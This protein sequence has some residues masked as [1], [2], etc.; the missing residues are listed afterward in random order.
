M[1][2]ATWRL[3]A[4]TQSAGLAGTVRDASGAAVPQAR[5][6]IQASPG[7]YREVVMT[8]IAGEYSIFGLPA[9][10]YDISVSKPGF[11]LVEMKGIETSES[12]P[13]RVDVLLN[14][15]R[16]RETLTVSAERVTPVLPPPASPSRPPMIRVGGSVQG[17]KI[18]A[19]PQPAYPPECK[20]EGI[21][22]LVILR[23]VIGKDGSVLKLERVNKL[24]DARLADA[25][26]QAV[27]NW[28]YQPTLLN[29]EPVEVVT[30]IEVNFTLTA[31]GKRAR[32]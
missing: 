13:A 19:M 5:V 9:G 16:I 14:I 11:A 31:L 27:Q 28:R 4:G 18:T 7:D 15:G 22:G 2:L 29:G 20:A 17:A 1:T 10:T 3:P 12:N 25:A 8:N 32:R 23:A 6:T 24:V 30:E 21:E 26:M